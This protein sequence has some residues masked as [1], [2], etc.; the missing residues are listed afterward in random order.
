MRAVVATIRMAGEE[1]VA[2]QARRATAKAKMVKTVMVGLG[3]RLVML[4]RPMSDSGTY[5]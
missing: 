4:A 5:K 3:S 1:G 2:K